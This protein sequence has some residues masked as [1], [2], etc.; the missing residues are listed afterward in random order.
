MDRIKLK[1]GKN[2]RNGVIWHTQGT[3]KTIIM[4]MLTKMIQRDK[5][6]VNPRFILVTDRK[7]LDKQIRDNFINT[8]MRPVRA[9]TGKGLVN[10]IKDEGNS[11]ITTVV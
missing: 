7:N 10:L 9:A 3:G 1:D 6:I 5:D 11:V 4:I 8:N 2:T